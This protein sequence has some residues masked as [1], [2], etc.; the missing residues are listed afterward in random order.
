MVTAVL[1]GC[2]AE[3]QPPADPFTPAV[4]AGFRPAEFPEHGMALDVPRGWDLRRRPAPGV[5][6]MSSGDASIAVF[7]YRRR[8]PLPAD[9][10]ALR[11][12]RERLVEEVRLRDPSFV[13]GEATTLRVDGA[14]AVQVLGTQT[15]LRR[16]LRVRSTH[17]F[18]DRIE[19]VIDAVASPQTFARTDREAFAPV[20]TS[21][22]VSGRPRS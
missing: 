14:L 4:P 20:L 11:R 19:Y 16:R 9:T 5:V 7:A 6:T 1:A 13:L 12:A 18:R 2:G 8:E 22:E 10:P 21:L 3:R 17:V 15:V